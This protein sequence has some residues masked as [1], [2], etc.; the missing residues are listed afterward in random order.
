MRIWHC[1]RPMKTRD[2][3]STV[4]FYGLIHG[5]FH[6]QHTSSGFQARVLPTHL[7]PDGRMCYTWENDSSA[8][9]LAT[10]R[11]TRNDRSYRGLEGRVSWNLASTCRCLPFAGNRSRSH[12]W[13]TMLRRPSGLASPPCVL[14]IISP[15]PVPG[16]R[17]S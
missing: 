15:S 1:T 7:D 6:F 11:E 12:D 16:S 17:V 9:V 2:S 8:F 3:C 10:R 13:L 14:T 5:F 4:H